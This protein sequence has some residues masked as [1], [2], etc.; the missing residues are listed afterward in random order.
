M[1][2]LKLGTSEG[3]L[4]YISYMEFRNVECKVGSVAQWWRARLA[5]GLSWLEGIRSSVPSAGPLMHVYA[6]SLA[7]VHARGHTHIENTE[8]KSRTAVTRMWR[9]KDS[10]IEVR[11]YKLSGRHDA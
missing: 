6:C 2:V 3:I 8:M 5:G 9:Y 4:E 10:E 7:L 11:G 1:I